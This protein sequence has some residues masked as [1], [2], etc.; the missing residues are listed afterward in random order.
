[1][2][3]FYEAIIKIDLRSYKV[4]LITN[5]FFLRSQIYVCTMSRQ[6]L[7]IL[8]RMQLNNLW[9]TALLS[10]VLSLHLLLVFLS[11]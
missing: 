3:C 5:V 6:L 4:V 2:I 8:G 7:T 9:Q 10:R 1:M 11:I